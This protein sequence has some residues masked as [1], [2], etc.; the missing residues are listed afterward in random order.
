MRLRAVRF[1]E[2]NQKAALFLA[3][4]VSTFIFRLFALYDSYNTL[5]EYPYAKVKALLLNQKERIGQN[6]HRYF[7]L[8]FRGDDFDFKTLS[9]ISHER[10]KDKYVS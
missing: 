2:Q 9:N 5:T 3:L 7:V 8:Y 1:L 4:I 6:G 10:F